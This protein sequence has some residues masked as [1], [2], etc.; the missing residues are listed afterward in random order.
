MRSVIVAIALL[1]GG[2]AFAEDVDLPLS[3][4]NSGC[5]IRTQWIGLVR[6]V[7]RV[8]VLQCG[9]ESFIVRTPA[10]LIGHVKIDTPEKAL[11]FVRFFTSPDRYVLFDTGSLV[12]VVP[13]DPGSAFNVRPRLFR[14]YLQP[15]AVKEEDNPYT[16]EL[17]FLCG[18]HFEVTRSLAAVDNHVYLVTESVYESGVYAVTRKKSIVKNAESIGV[19]HFGDY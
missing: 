10:S 3:S 7:P 17:P 18:H 6:L 11:E 16:P 4:L 5:S 19:F 9:G 12:E 14:K 15:P 2:R 8:A 1:W 13:G